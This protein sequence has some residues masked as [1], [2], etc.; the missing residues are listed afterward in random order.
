MKVYNFAWIMYRNTCKSVYN[1][2]GSNFNPM[3]PSWFGEA[4]KLFCTGL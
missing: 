1:S 3:D 2:N 4:V